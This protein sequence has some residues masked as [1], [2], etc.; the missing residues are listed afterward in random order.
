MRFKVELHPIIHFH[1]MG[2]S[3]DVKRFEHSSHNDNGPAPMIN[4]SLKP[5]YKDE[6][7]W[8]TYMGW[9]SSNP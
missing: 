9:T 3:N 6:L 5:T 7:T 2:W 8:P 1:H 4:D